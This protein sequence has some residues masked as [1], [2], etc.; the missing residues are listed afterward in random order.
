[1][2]NIGRMMGSQDSGTAFQMLKVMFRSLPVGTSTVYTCM[3][4]AFIVNT[5]T[6]VIHKLLDCPSKTPL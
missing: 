5:C 1:M 2:L 4:E 3:T 6:F